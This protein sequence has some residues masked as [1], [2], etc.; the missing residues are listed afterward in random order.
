LVKKKTWQNLEE[1]HVNVFG[2]L[3]HPDSWL[4]WNE[5]GM[6]GKKHRLH[7]MRMHVVVVAL[8]EMI[9]KELRI[10]GVTEVRHY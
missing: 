8:V 6:R 5:W 3:L 2:V 10:W 7:E 4:S 1:D 9:V